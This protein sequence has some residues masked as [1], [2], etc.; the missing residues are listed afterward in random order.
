ML[1]VRLV[2]IFAVVVSA[3]CSQWSPGERPTARALV[4]VPGA[5]TSSEHGQ[6]VQGAWV[7]LLTSEKRPVD[8][9]TTDS[10]GRFMLKASSPGTYDVQVRMIA[11]RP[12]RQT[13]ELKASVNDTLRLQLK[14]DTT[15][16]ISDCIGPDGWSFGSQFCR[17]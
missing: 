17:H 3:S 16:L 10:L 15:G 7:R 6:V 14:S 12:L 4:S 11:H 1:A 9:T 2:M 13:V 8:S 5:V